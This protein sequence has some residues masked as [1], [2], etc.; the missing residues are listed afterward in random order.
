MTISF[1]AA[2][3][4]E[5]VSCVIWLPVD[6]IKERLQV[7]N[8]LKTYHYKN[9]WDAAIQISKNEGFLALYKAYGATILSFGMF[10]GINLACYEKCKQFYGFRNDQPTFVQAFLLAFTTG[11]VASLITNP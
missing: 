4:A 6:V 1:S 2:I 10:G 5:V 7:Q 8:L 9:S 11:A 3:I